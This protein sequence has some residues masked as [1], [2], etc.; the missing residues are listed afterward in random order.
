MQRYIKVE[1]VLNSE[2]HTNA[3]GHTDRKYLFL[4]NI[5]I[6]HSTH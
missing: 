2:I 6:S 4:T 1:L 5:F 3:C